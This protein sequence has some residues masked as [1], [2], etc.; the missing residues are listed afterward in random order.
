ML[1]KLHNGS[2]TLQSVYVIL[3][4]RIS[5]LQ[6]GFV[7]LHGDSATLRCDNVILHDYKTSLQGGYVKKFVGFSTTIACIMS[8]YCHCSRAFIMQVWHKRKH[9]F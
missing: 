6:S 8:Q 3:H 4:R 1:V 2:T 5:S 7:I 9:F